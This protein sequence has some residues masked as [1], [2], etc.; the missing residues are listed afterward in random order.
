MDFRLYWF[1]LR[2]KLLAMETKPMF[3]STGQA[4]LCMSFRWN[5]GENDDSI[6]RS[7]LEEEMRLEHLQN[8]AV[9]N[10]EVEENKTDE[11][12]PRRSSIDIVNNSCETL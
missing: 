2:T 12:C 4:A 11:F 8:T 5:P 7:L 10:N 6:A 9:S 3:L 1:E